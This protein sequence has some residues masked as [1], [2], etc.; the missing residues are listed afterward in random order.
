LPLPFPVFIIDYE[1]ILI[2]R[3]PMNE[4]ELYKLF[5][6]V[7]NFRKAIDKCDNS[8]LSVSFKNF[9]KGNCSDAVLIL[10]HY[11]KEK[12]YGEFDYVSGERWNVPHAWLVMDK[13]VI[14]ISCDKFE[15]QENKVI[16]TANSKWHD[17]FITEVRQ[18]TSLNMLEPEIKD[19]L[20]NCYKKIVDGIG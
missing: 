12:G 16:V 10:A 18:K 3:L 9:P 11:L 13:V 6:V 2:S 15:D 20:L 14:D 4:L 8:E 19:R 17:E 1:N 7:L 5:K